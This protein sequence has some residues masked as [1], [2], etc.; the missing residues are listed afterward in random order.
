MTDKE[1]ST[2][3]KR[4]DKLERQNRDEHKGIMDKLDPL[5]EEK[6]FRDKIDKSVD[7]WVDRSPKIAMIAGIIAAV[8]YKIV[9]LVNSAP[10]PGK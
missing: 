3:I 2:I 7:K 9:L 4:L 10:T 8:I 1:I 5:I 6:R